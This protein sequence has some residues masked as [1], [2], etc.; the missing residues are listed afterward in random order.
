M[1]KSKKLAT[2]KALARKNPT[3]FPNESK[4]YRRAR[5]DLLAKEIKLRRAMEAVAVARRKLPPGGRVPENYVFK[6]IGADGKTTEV[7]LSELFARGKDTLIVYN[8]M[9]PRDA[10][11]ERPGPVEGETAKLKRE[12]SPCPS[13]VAFI[14]ALDAAAEHLEAAGFNFAVIAKTPLDRLTAFAKERGWRHARMLS[15]AGSS[16]KR[17]YHAETPEGDQRPMMTVFHKT[18]DGIEHFWSSEMF[19]VHSDPG[20]DPRHVGTI[21]PVWNL[22]D[23]T[24]E[25]RPAK[26]DEQIVY[27]RPNRP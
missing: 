8:F 16:F 15:S 14:D 5:D 27:D 25:G 11:D 17:D 2:P 12:D 4:K 26:W 19:Y 10:G 13:C 18:R 3:R 9:F 24:P 22:M 6:G 7:K 20:Q 21:E 1:A 23:L